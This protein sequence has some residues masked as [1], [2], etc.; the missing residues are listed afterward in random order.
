MALEITGKVINVLAEQTGSGK[1]GTWVKQDFVIET[2]EQ[3]PK[4][5]CCAA[6]GDKVAIVKGL[7]IGDQ[8]K[9]SFNIESRE[10]NERWYT[11]LRAWKIEIGAGTGDSTPTPTAKKETFPG[12]VST[13]TADSGEG[14]DLPF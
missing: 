5:V 10:Y 1:N 8:V 2:N 9:V 14:D 13:F 3:Y 4:K 12:D 6:W 7:T 11:E